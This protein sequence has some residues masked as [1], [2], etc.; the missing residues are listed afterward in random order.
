[1]QSIR[2]PIP[3]SKVS[4]TFVSFRAKRRIPVFSRTQARFDTP[5]RQFKAEEVD[6]LIR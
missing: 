5:I 3:S 6:E 1:V 2:V 4:F